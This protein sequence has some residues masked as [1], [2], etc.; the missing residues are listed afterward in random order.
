MIRVGTIKNGRVPSYPGYRVIKVLTKSSPYGELG[1]Y[2]LKDE[3]GR[4]M[5]NIWQFSKVYEKVPKTTQRYSQ[6][7][8]TIIWDHPEEI[9]VKDGELT[10]EYHAWREK[11]MRCEYGVRYPVGY[12]K[13]A[14]AACLYAFRDG[15]DEKLDYVEA[16]VKIYFHWYRK[17]AKKEKKF[18]YLKKLLEKGENLLIVEVDGPISSSLPYY[19]EK[20]N[21][22]DSFIENDTIEVNE[23]NMEIMLN[24]TLH[25]FGH[26]YCLA[27]AL[28]DLEAEITV[29]LR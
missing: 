15:K 6:W 9:H 8:N 1:P 14:R 12:T 23:K 28:L 2:V 5:E 4:I 19:K 18:S 25:P 26:G 29:P 10:P 13:Q 7:D 20:Y 21:V 17:L 24:D 22:D 27:M 16:R 3:K 11:G